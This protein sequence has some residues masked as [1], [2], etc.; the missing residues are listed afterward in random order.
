[1]PASRQLADKPG[2]AADGEDQPE[3]GLVPFLGGEIDGEERTKPGLDVGHKKGKP[4]KTALTAPGGSHR[5]RTF[6]NH[7]TG[8]PR[9]SR[10]VVAIRFAPAPG[11][12]LR[13]ACI[14]GRSAPARG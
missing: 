2:Q 5:S 1:Q 4:I 12:D 14:R 6:V 9:S 13:P 10:P 11:R 3:I 7:Q 8:E